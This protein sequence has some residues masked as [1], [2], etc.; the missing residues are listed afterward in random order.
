MDGQEINRVLLDIYSKLYDRF[1]PQHWWPAEEP[2][3]VIIGAILTQSTAWS[4]VE[5]AIANLKESGVMSAASLR[6]LPE[7]KLAELIYPSGYYNAKARKIK[8]FVQW[9]GDKYC[10]NPG[11]LFNQDISYLRKQL[12]GVYGIGEETADS[13]ILYAAEK[14]VFV[15]DAYTRR[16]IKRLGLAPLNNS[17]S[18]CQSLF[19]D[20]IP[21]DSDLFNE[22]HALIV[23]HGKDICRKTPSCEICCLNET[24]QTGSQ[25]VPYPCSALIN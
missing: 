24:G 10:D 8:A 2:F 9:L 25:Q 19:T 12:L 4:N 13:I 15:I 1:G 23:R 16:L 17:Y 14:P 22:Y 3:E 20:H 21:A 6:E 7:P 18:T 5:K 11:R